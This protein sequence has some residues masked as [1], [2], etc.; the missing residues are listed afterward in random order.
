[1]HYIHLRLQKL[2]YLSLALLMAASGCF[3]SIHAQDKIKHLP[4]KEK[5]VEV[6]RLPDLNIP[7]ST[8]R[9]YYL[10]GEY[11]TFGGHT[12][13]FIPTPTAEYYRDGK[14][15]VMEMVYTHDGGL[16]IPLKSGKVLLVG[17]FEKHLGI[18]Q[19]FVV[20][21]YDPKTHQFEGFGCLNK[22]RA[23]ASAVE[24]D[25]GRVIISGNWYDTD[26]IEQF[27][28]HKTFSF[29]KK[30]SA[31]RTSPFML[32]VSKDNSL[33]F[34]SFGTR[35]N[36][37][38]GKIWVDQLQGEPFTVPLF[39]QWKPF[40]YSEQNTNNANWFIGNEE[41][42]QYAYLIPVQNKNGETGLV[43]VQDTTFTLI[44]TTTAIPTHSKDSTIINYYFPL[45]IDRTIQR[46]Y[47]IGNNANK[48]QYCVAIDYAK[49]PAPVTVFYTD[50]ITFE[51]ATVTMT[52]NGDILMVGGIKADEYNFSP[53]STAYLLKVGRHTAQ[54]AQQNGSNIW[55]WLG[56][57]AFVIIMIGI[58]V[59]IYIKR[60]KQEET[61]T[62][63]DE[64]QDVSEKRR[65]I[66]DDELIAT[67]CHVMEEEQV[68]L[69]SNLK[70]AD[71]PALVHTNS[72][73]VTDCIKRKRG[74]SFSQ[75]VNTYRI[76]H[77][78]QL[79]LANRNEKLAIV[80]IQS[81]FANETSF[82]RTF[83]AITGLTPR[84]WLSAQN[85]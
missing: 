46:A 22:K 26:V 76:H 35:G 31:Q 20:E 78:K 37:I 64:Y 74:C 13:G 23:L 11:V 69:N 51:G 1:M 3:A 32:R 42:G 4:V 45:T 10:N 24:M 59:I 12:T 21:R 40:Q 84:E 53:I 25:N 7:R 71:M 36:T 41:K 61:M 52:P 82:F 81:G 75:F 43:H 18:G 19:T 38:N 44:P 50:S 15:H 73:Y 30:P 55:L 2:R 63:N 68:Y 65:N 85:D 48:R 58:G 79:L 54:E 29:L 17:G 5:E 60:K 33:I 16:V 28:G 66:P 80:A 49:R 8:H 34:G 83:K 39:D 6:E 27:D 56:G 72:R 70:L 14:W 57:S 77:A 67:I 47:L 9:T 62:T